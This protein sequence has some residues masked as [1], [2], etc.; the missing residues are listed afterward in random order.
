MHRLPLILCAIALLGS[1]VSA[2]LYFHIGNSKQILEFRLAES[3]NRT[4]RLESD[5]AAAHTQTSS[6]QARAAS[7]DIEL[8]RT[9]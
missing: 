7:L 3:S 8:A 5:L 2:V 1:S 4:T 9:G 6:L